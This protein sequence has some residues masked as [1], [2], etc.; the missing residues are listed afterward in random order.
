MFW[1]EFFIFIMGVIFGGVSYLYYEKCYKVP[2]LNFNK[3]KK[4]IIDDL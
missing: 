2:K 3:K 4:E 1:H